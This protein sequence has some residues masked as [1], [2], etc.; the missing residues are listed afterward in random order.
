MSNPARGGMHLKTQY[1]VASSLDG[2]IAAPEHAL[3]WLLQFGSV[4]DT[5]YPAFVRDVGAVAMG[6]HTYEWILQ[7]REDSDPEQRPEWPYEQ[8][9]WVLRL[10]RCRPFRV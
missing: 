9:V 6:S 1:Y 10:V 3:D 5:S 7:N 8:P 2:F 4:E